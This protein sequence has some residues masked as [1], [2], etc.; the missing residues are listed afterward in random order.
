MEHPI[1]QPLLLIRDRAAYSEQTIRSP[2]SENEI[3]VTHA[4]G[5]R[6]SRDGGEFIETSVFELREQLANSDRAHYVVSLSNSDPTGNRTIDASYTVNVKIANKAEM[7]RVD[8]VFVQILTV[9]NLRMSDVR[10]FS[11]VCAKHRGADE[12]TS[13]MAEYVTGVLIKNQDGN[14][15]ITSE[16]PDRYANASPPTALVMATN[17]RRR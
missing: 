2:I 1:E 14:A 16:L 8:E 15:G 5:V 17:R 9:D 10:R 12:Y 7:D 6:V 3:A 11:E 13:A 4:S